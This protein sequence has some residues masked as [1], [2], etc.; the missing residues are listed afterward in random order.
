MWQHALDL[1][2]RRLLQKGSLLVTLPDGNS[3]RYGDGTGRQLQVQIHDTATVRHLV[4]NPELAFGEAY[5][6]STLTIDND[7]L[8]GLLA[9]FIANRDQAPPVWWQR[10]LPQIRIALRRYSQ[11]NIAR[12]SVRNVAHHYDLS[13]DL[14]ELFLDADRQ[15]SCGYFH[16]ADDTLEQAQANKKHHIARKL[17]IAPDMR[18]LDVGSGWGGMAL[19]LARDYGAKVVGITLSRQ[20]HAYAVANAARQGLS[21]RVSFRLCDYR[22]VTGTFDRIV[23]IG[24]F[25]HVGLP[26]YNTYFSAIRDLLA[27]DGIALLHTIGW[28]GQTDATN[29][30][31]AKYIFPGGY[32]PTLSEVAKAVE[33]SHLWAADI[34]VLRLH[35][36]YTLQHWTAR[37]N[38][39]E[40]AIRDLYDDR[41]VRMWRF[42]LTA[43]EQTFR[44]GRQAVFQ[45]QLSRKIDAVPLVR[46]YLYAPQRTP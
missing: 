5:M 24:M 6:N 37:F 42:Y 9:L 25:E 46:D 29:P 39:N 4:R 38:E 41:F 33:R 17:M 26:H 30:W 13:D 27:P 22:E 16:N 35:Y 44:Y 32:I 43:C 12:R 34:E 18:V 40:Q 10:F 15:Y 11:N 3:A 1:M 14:Y 31:I 20:Q 36:A 19:T 8:K 28:T 7:D 23:S 2:L 45:I 21:G